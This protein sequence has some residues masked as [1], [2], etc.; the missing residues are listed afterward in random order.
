[1]KMKTK[2]S[3]Y[4]KDDRTAIVFLDNGV[5]A[6]EFM[7]SDNPIGYRYFPNHSLRYAED[8]AENWILDI[9]KVND[10]SKNH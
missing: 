9:I 6:V 5:H 1:M 8:A 2:L 7:I 4:M 10:V 3:E